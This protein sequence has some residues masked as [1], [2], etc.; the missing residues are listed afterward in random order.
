LSSEK[1][2]FYKDFDEALTTLETMIDGLKG[3]YDVKEDPQPDGPP[4]GRKLAAP[5]QVPPMLGK[6]SS[7][8]EEP[9]AQI[10]AKRVKG[11]AGEELKKDKNLEEEKEPSRK[12]DRNAGKVANYNIDDLIDA[13]LK[14]DNGKVGGGCISVMLAQTYSPD[15]CPDPTGWLMSEKLDG[16]RCYW[17]GSAMYT[18][19]GNAFYPPDWFKKALPADMALDGELWSKREDFQKIVSVVRRQD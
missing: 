10:G 4:H 9:P 6:R 11:A 18:R 12:S 8:K 17:N 15:L 5:K 14:E 13:S 3:E 16:V 19:N 2:K 7:R 1:K